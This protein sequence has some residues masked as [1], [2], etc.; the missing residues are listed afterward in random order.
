MA[1]CVV[2]VR[3]WLCGVVPRHYYWATVTVNLR[4]VRVV[5]RV[6]GGEWAGVTLPACLPPIITT[7]VVTTVVVIIIIIIII[8]II[9][10]IVI[11][12]VVVA[13]REVHT[14]QVQRQDCRC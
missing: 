12:I 7:V 8:V 13:R 4:L 9:I 1:A 10:V 3:V 6:A 11:V 14:M 5:G 2:R